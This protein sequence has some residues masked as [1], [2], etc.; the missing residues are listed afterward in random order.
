MTGK[1]LER[2]A[3][4]IRTPAPIARIV[5]ISGVCFFMESAEIEAKIPIKQ[6]LTISI[7]KTRKAFLFQ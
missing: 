5:E 1:T 2:I 3:V 6:I 7:A 4:N